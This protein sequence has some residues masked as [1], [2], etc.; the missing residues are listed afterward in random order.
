[1]TSQKVNLMRQG[2]NRAWNPPN[3]LLAKMTGLPN[4]ENITDVER[5]RILRDIALRKL[6]GMMRQGGNP[7]RYLA[8]A[9]LYADRAAEKALA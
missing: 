7:L 2:G 8:A 3:A 4:L 1:M 9:G 6:D 5:L